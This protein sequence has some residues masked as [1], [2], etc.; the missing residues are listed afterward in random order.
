MKQMVLV[1]ALLIAA[2]LVSFSDEYK[3]TILVLKSRYNSSQKILDN[4][5]KTKLEMSRWA[6]RQGSLGD[7]M[8]WVCG[9]FNGDGKCDKAK[10]FNDAGKVSID[11]HV[12]NNGTFEMQRWATQVGYFRD[13]QNFVSGDFNGDGKCDIIKLYIRGSGSINYSIF[14]SKNNTFEEKGWSMTGG[15]YSNGTKWLSGDF[16]GDGKWDVYQVEVKDR[17]TEVRLFYTSD[18]S[19]RFGQRSFEILE[20]FDHNQKWFSGDFNGDSLCDIATIANKRGYDMLYVYTIKNFEKKNIQLE[21]PDFVRTVNRNIGNVVLMREPTKLGIQQQWFSGDFNGDARCD[22][23]KS[24][25]DGGEASIIIYLSQDKIFRS[26]QWATRQGA[27]WDSQKWMA[28]DYT[29]DSK[30]DISKVFI[31][32]NQATIDVHRLKQ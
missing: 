30:C 14:T 22:M 31:D 7:N 21:N 17:V 8:K 6:T 11:V 4:S 10:A 26:E 29:G 13:D 3:E 27:Y 28:G 5:V 32:D 9:D 16:N 20:E 18:R 15:S 23:A 1:K 19:S 12:S 25:N 24:F 2:I